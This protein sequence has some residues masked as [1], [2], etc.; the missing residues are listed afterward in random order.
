[1]CRSGRRCGGQAEGARVE[2]PGVPPLQGL[3]HSGPLGPELGAAGA[4]DG[5]QPDRAVPALVAGLPPPV[6]GP[7]QEVLEAQDPGE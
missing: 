3:A 2:D 1:M 6:P 7:S 5:G 4:L